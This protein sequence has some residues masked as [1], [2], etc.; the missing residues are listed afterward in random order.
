[1]SLSATFVVS[2]NYFLTVGSNHELD[3]EIEGEDMFSREENKNRF[4]CEKIAVIRQRFGAKLAILLIALATVALSACATP[5]A[6]SNAVSNSKM[7]TNAAGVMNANNNTAAVSTNAFATKE[8]EQYSLT[9]SITGQGTANNKQ[10]TLQPQTIEFARLNTD[11]R[12]TVTLLLVGQVTYLEKPEMRYLILPSR[13]QYV[14]LSPDAL[15]FQ[16]GNMM[17]PSAMVEHLKPRTQYENLGTE[18]INGRT[19]TK[20]RFVGETDTHTQAGTVQSDTYVYIDEATGLLLR[21]DL[22][23]ASSSGGT[24]NG[25]LETRDINLNP[26]PKL[27]SLPTGYKKMTTEELKEQIQSFIQFIRVFAPLMSQQSGSTPA[28]QPTPTPQTTPQST[29]PPNSNRQ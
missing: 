19:A 18:T 3:K 1:L 15:G 22:N 17:T 27:F 6:N 28:P 12:W 13:T 24:A 9:M 11:R 16:L 10:A 7:N 29:P 4:K 2:S 8:P 25:V 14:E 23:F 21:A 5:P 20:Y 26:D